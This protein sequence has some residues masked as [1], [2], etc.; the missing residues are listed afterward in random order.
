MSPTS[1]QTALPRDQFPIALYYSTASGPIFRGQPRASAYEFHLVS[2]HRETHY[3][4]FMLLMQTAEIGGRHFCLVASILKLTVP[5]GRAIFPGG[6]EATLKPG[7]PCSLCP[8]AVPEIFFPCP[9]PPAE[10]AALW[11]FIPRP[12]A[13]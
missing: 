11:G 9:P 8:R 5:F 13:R 7:L 10:L 1:Y 4:G 2:I 12:L 3:A 6:P